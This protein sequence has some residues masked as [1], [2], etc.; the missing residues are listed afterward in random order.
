LVITKVHLYQE[1]TT[2]VAVNLTA[3]PVTVVSVAN[4][5]WLE[6]PAL[7]N[8][9]FAAPLVPDVPEN[10][11]VPEKPDVPEVPEVPMPEV[12]LVPL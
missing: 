3:E 2:G 8:V 10:P 4:G 7:K 1:P 12:P 6:S 11:L 5:A 9:V